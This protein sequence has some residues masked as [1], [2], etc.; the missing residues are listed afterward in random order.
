MSGFKEQLNDHFPGLLAPEV[1]SALTEYGTLRSVAAG[2]SLIEIGSFVKFM[3]L[4]TQGAIKVVR[5]DEN[6]HEVFLYFLYPG[7]SCAMTVQC[8]LADAPSQ[9]YAV[10]EDETQFIAI[11][12]TRLDDL[13]KHRPWRDFVLRTYNERFGELLKTIDSLVFQKLDERILEYLR[14]KARVSGTQTI[15][16]THQQ[17][18]FDFEQFPER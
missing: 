12:S 18:A 16:A 4:V 1:L 11:P 3:P 5:E 10:A 14:S 6:G 2:T 17:I 8:C 15:H 9:I 13:M 7:Q